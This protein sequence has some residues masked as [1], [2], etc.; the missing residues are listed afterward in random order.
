MYVCVHSCMCVRMCVRADSEHL[1]ASLQPDLYTHEAVLHALQVRALVH[2]MWDVVTVLRLGFCIC[3]HVCVCVCVCVRATR[4]A[5]ACVCMSVFYWLF[6]S[7][8][9]CY[10]SS[11]HQIVSSP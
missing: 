6:K 2:L 8:V 10:H 1:L 4:V 7:R 5:R 11:Q 9:S 3:A